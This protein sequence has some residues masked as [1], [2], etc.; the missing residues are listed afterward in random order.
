MNDT[1][2]IRLIEI[3]VPALPERLKLIRNTLRTTA[4]TVGCS[5]T[6]R[7]DIVM[8]VDEACQ[9]IIRHGYKN[10]PDGLITVD[11]RLARD[12]LVIK[13]IDYAQPVVVEQVKSRDLEDIRP[14]GLG[15]HIIRECM[16]E[17]E[18]KRPPEGAGNLLEL[19]KKIV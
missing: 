3:T 1:D 13:L 14:G 12:T 2:E 10:D 9:N 6:C 16:D 17:A 5:E 18:F 19:T 7:Q 8:A 15:V 11:V 4:E